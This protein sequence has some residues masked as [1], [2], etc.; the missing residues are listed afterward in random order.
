MTKAA[1][2][3]VTLLAAYPFAV[4]FSAAYTEG[5]FLL[6]LVG[7][8]YH[9]R[10]TSCGGGVLGIRL[11]ADAAQRLLPVGRARLDGRR[12]DVGCRAVATN[13]AAAVGWPAIGKRCSGRGAGFGM[14][15]FPHTSTD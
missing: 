11:R 5:L 10:R 1:V 13:S 6:T 9:F 3:A 12:A 15:R 8:V 7:A 14:L 2:T 4:F